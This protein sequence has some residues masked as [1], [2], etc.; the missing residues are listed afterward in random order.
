MDEMKVE[1]GVKES[2]KKIGDGY[3]GWSCRKWDM[4]N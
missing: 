4:K 2:S 3:M 1:V